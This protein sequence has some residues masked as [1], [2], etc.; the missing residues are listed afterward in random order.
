MQAIAKALTAD[1]IL[2]LV[3]SL[4]PPPITPSRIEAR[5][6]RLSKPKRGEAY[7]HECAAD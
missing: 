2:P 6:K 4:K 3:A 1:D 5:G 7:T